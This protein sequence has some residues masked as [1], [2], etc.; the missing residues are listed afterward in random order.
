MKERTVKIVEELF[1]PG[2]GL[3]GV[4]DDALRAAE[5]IKSAFTQGGK[6]M[7]CGNGGSWADSEH[8]VGELMK[9]FHLKRPLPLADRDE[10]VRLWGPE[11]EEMA[12][13]LQG[14]LPAISLGSCGALLTAFANDVDARFAFAQQAIGYARAGDAAIGISTSG[15]A[16]NVR[17]AL[18][19]AKSRG[20]VT[21]G[22]AGQGGGRL[23][24]V[25]DCCILAPDDRTFRVQEHHA[26]IYHFL[27]AYVES[28]LFEE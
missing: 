27:C 10:L 15:N 26:R 28:E 3:E 9:G 6:L 24:E 23:A 20:A 11:G 2:G 12:D 7:V 13:R 19:A 21:I 4:R 25:A 1:S 17:F 5:L 8:I 16:D 18:M 14:A 22:L